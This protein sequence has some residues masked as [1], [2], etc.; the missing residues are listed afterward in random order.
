MIPKGWRAVVNPSTHLIQQTQIHNWDQFLSSNP[1]VLIF[2]NTWSGA[3]FF[4]GN[5]APALLVRA[6]RFPVSCRYIHISSPENAVNIW[7]FCKPFCDHRSRNFGIKNTS[8]STEFNPSKIVLAHK[9]ERTMLNFWAHFKG[10]TCRTIYI[11]WAFHFCES[12]GLARGCQPLHSHNT[13]NTDSKMR[14]VF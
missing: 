9:R 8:K 6:K 12:E 13:A 1:L 11:I 10:K 2:N 4:L 7:R 14:P 3:R 5:R